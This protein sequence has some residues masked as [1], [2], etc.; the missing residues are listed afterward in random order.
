[1]FW[2]KTI[3]LYNKCED[4]QTG[5]IRWYRHKLTN[6]FYKVTDNKVNIGNVQLQTNDNIIRIPEQRDYLPPYKWM[7]LPNDKKGDQMTLQTGDL[8][9][10][11]D[12]QED[13]DELISGKRSSDLIAKHKTVGSVFITSVNINDFVPGAHYFIRGE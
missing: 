5:L 10:L 3:T 4:E 8:I 1:M 7:E 13:I 2:D 9:F 12:I 11:G 6:C